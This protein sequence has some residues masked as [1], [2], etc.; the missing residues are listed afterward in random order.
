MRRR[1]YHRPDLKMPY[2][3]S[4][5][6]SQRRAASA[7]QGVEEARR[8]IRHDMLQG[9]EEPAGDREADPAEKTL[10]AFQVAQGEEKS[11]PGVSREM[12]DLSREHR[13]RPQGAGNQGERHNRKNARP[14]QY[15]RGP[16]AQDIRRG[17][18]SVIVNEIA[19]PRL[20]VSFG[21]AAAGRTRS[22]KWP[23]WSL[24]HSRSWRGLL[25]RRF[26]WCRS[27]TKIGRENAVFA[28]KFSR[29]R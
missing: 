29:L 27:K 17:A 3:H 7:R 12:F 11:G 15:T 10:L 26:A 25:T 19:Q 21:L 13:M 6:E 20:L 8:A 18:S 9:F 24:D 28:A 23:R 22:S 5:N 14:G 2:Y 16:H 4:R 1:S